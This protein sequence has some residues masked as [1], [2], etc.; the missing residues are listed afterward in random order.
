M[1]KT[2]LAFN[3]RKVI[4]TVRL[5]STVHGNDCNCIGTFVCPCE[6]QFD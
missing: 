2:G 6:A 1:Y 4:N 3:D 5:N